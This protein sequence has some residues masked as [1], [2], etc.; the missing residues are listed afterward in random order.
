MVSFELFPVKYS[1]TALLPNVIWAYK[2]K[3]SLAH[4]FADLRP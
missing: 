2:N 1:P 3:D 4:R